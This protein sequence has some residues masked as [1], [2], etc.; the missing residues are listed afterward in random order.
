[1]ILGIE[2]ADLKKMP[3]ANVPSAETQLSVGY[4]SC[5]GIIYAHFHNRKSNV[6]ETDFAFGSGCVL[7][8]P[9]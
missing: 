7:S 5:C 6:N 3:L 1:M 8:V 4:T 2:T 9:S